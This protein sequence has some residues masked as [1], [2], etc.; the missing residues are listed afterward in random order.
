MVAV[1]VDAET[2]VQGAGIDAWAEAFAA[3]DG[4][5]RAIG[6]VLLEDIEQRFQAE[7]DPWGKAW[8]PLSDVTIALREKAGKL[9]KKLQVDRLLA[10]SKAYRVVDK[11]VTVFLGGPAAAYARVHQ[12]GNPRNKFFGKGRAPIPA[13]PMMPVKKRG[14]AIPAALMAEIKATFKDAL[15]QVARRSRSAG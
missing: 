14:P 8:A 9:G 5:L 11:T 3:P 13:R 6:E 12:F 1:A 15:M 7:T 4:A 10:N 2:I